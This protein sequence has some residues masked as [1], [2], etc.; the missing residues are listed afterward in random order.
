M[1]PIY[2]DIN[3][4]R[5]SF[6]DV[7]L[8]VNGFS[9][10]GIKSFNY[11]EEHTIP[12]IYGTSSDP[13]G[14]TRGQRKWSGEIEWYKEE[15]KAMLVVLTRGG[16]FGFAEVSNA[17][18]IS[19]ATL[20]SPLDTE[21]DTLVGVRIHSPKKSG[22]EGAEALTVKTSLSIMRVLHSG[23]FEGLRNLPF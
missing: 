11:D 19:Y 18:S 3:G 13:I 7:R 12:E 20:L 6:C 5:V 23:P 17:I 2:P 22:A 21:T 4:N 10:R 8:G 15:W 16:L 1:P 9:L 14:R